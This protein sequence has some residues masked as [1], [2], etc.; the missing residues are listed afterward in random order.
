MNIRLTISN[1]CA[2]AAMLL[3]VTV[4]SIGAWAQYGGY[5]LSE[6]TV[7]G[8]DS[9]LLKGNATYQATYE[10]KIGDVI[11]LEG[12][13]FN[14]EADYYIVIKSS[15]SGAPKLKIDHEKK[16][17]SIDQEDMV[18]YNTY[19]LA[20][21][22]LSFK[23]TT[24]SAQDSYKDVSFSFVRFEDSN[25]FVV[26]DSQDGLNLKLLADCVN[27][28]ITFK[29]ENFKLGKDITYLYDEK[30][31]NNYTPIGGYYNNKEKNFLGHFDGD[32]HTISGVRIND[33]YPSD[34][35]LFG[36]LGNG[37]EVKNLTL[38][39]AI[40]YGPTKTG[41]IAGTNSG[42]TITN[43]HVTSSVKISASTNDVIYHGGIVG[44]N[45]EKGTVSY[46][47]SS[48]TIERSN[49][50][51]NYYGVIAGSN[52]SNCTLDHNLAFG[53]DLPK[54]TGYY[55]GAITG[56]NNGILKYN[57]YS[58]ITFHYITQSSDDGHGCGSQDGS[59]DVPEDD[60]A[61]SAI[62]Y[63]GLEESVNPKTGSKIAFRREFTG[64]TAS[65]I[66]LP[67]GYTPAGEGTYYTFSG[68]EKNYETNRWEA[69]FESTS[70][71]IYANY[72]YLFKPDTNTE[73]VLFN[74]TANK[75][76][77][78][79]TTIGDWT[80][81]GTYTIKTW[82]GF[83][84][85]KPRNAYGF[86]AQEIGSIHVG[87]F[88]KI[89]EYVRLRPMRCY[90][91]YTPTSSTRAESLT[92]EELPETIRVI[93]VDDGGK[94]DI[95]SLSTKTG[96]I[97]FDSDAWYSLDGKRFSTQPAQKGIYVNNGKKVV[98]K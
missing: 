17:L 72:P 37:A 43:C 87:D 78:P 61:I 3:L 89:G 71:S 23:A 97:T 88:V 74:G 58:Q 64:G 96:I 11:L 65:T 46:C 20:T 62:I 67:F 30:T 45:L 73:Y 41:G 84:D 54:T 60:G 12:E 80:F 33:D 47:T 2:R 83:D 66:V 10:V 49:G 1:L 19:S 32:G 57:Y 4:M 95:G 35:G 51:C 76:D 77:I 48:A 59:I 9:K 50:S 7:I 27:N 38:D 52:E 39:D 68:V 24:Y 42:G 85:G 55:Y 70:S 90:M 98:I 14:S 40:I 25:P 18:E 6:A 93:L 44:S 28:G 5:N 63:S 29:D 91:E 79:S 82:K 8:V 26:I 69:K 22:V 81:L 92:D 36:R 21:Y 53:A 13:N 56:R 75:S 16:T 94:T 34:V 86:A 15:S 31:Q